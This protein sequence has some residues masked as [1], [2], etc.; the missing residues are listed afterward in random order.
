MQTDPTNELRRMASSIATGRIEVLVDGVFA[1]VM[2]LLVFGIQVPSPEQVAAVGLAQALA[3]LAPNIFTYILTFIILGVFWVGHH[4]Q[5]F[6]IRRADRT[7]LWINILFMMCIALLPF[8]AGLFSRYGQDRLALIVYN[9]NLILVGLVLFLHWWYATR[10]SHLL[11][12]PIEQHA[13]HIVY[14]RILTPPFFYLLAMLI[15]FLRVD[16]S[17]LID[18]LIPVLYIMPAQLDH[19]FHRG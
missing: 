17:I 2:T 4:N 5:Y 16:L 18:V 12:H 1:I 14:R 13:R 3:Q 9:S 11:A 6:Y 15:A 8:S 7:L 10:D 19:L